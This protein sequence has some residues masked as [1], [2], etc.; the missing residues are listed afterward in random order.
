M[1]NL[2]PPKLS[3]VLESTR[4]LAQNILPKLRTR[5][6]FPFRTKPCLRFF[7]SA[8]RN[9]PNLSIARSWNCSKRSICT[10]FRSSSW[11]WPS[12]LPTTSDRPRRS[13]GLAASL[14]TSSL[15]HVTARTAAN[16]LATAYPYDQRNRLTNLGVNGTV[17]GAPAPIA[18]YAYTLDAAGHRIGV[19]ELNGRNVSYGYDNIYRLTSETIASDP[20]AV[21]G[22]VSYT[23]DAVGNRTQKVSS[24]PGYPGGLSNYNANDQLT[25]DTYDANGNTTASNARL[26]LR[27]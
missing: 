19:T 11:A 5:I 20:A 23:Y 3:R 27:F 24:L 16:D 15:V 7:R 12:P 13:Q 25:T 6:S 26:C 2:P 21:N 10:S 17:S 9:W 8:C 22:A 1:K 18:S 14:K 4:S